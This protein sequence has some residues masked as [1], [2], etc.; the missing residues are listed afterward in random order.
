LWKTIRIWLD[1][2]VN[3]PMI[4][5]GCFFL[6]TTSEVASNSAPFYLKSG[7]DRNVTKA[8]EIMALTASTSTNKTNVDAYTSFIDLGLD[9]RTSFLEKVWILDNSL[10]ISDLD[11]ELKR[12]LYFVS[13]RDNMNS[14]TT[15]LEGWW[16]SRVIKQLHKEHDI[17]IIS[18]ELYNEI[19]RLREQFSAE[20]LPIDDDIMRSD[21][22]EGSYEDRVFIHQLRIIGISNPKRIIFAIKDY[23]RAF[24]QRSRW[25]NEQ[26]LPINELDRYEDKLIELWDRKFQ[27]M[28]DRIGER[29]AEDKMKEAATTLY[30]W[31][32]SED[33][34]PIRSKVEESS[35]ARGSFHILSD[36]LTI[37][38]HPEFQQR[39]Q[40][41]LNK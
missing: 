4:S 2:V 5:T 22:D 7:T 12:E 1:I 31:I 16:T 32:E 19:N 11:S 10:S 13:S 24:S 33:L 8:S 21:I 17:P 38:W 27:Q 15:R 6:V 14:F 20:N 41:I 3:K 34:P 39:L 35:I 40:S 36:K 23:Y 37:G 28:K 18:E 26:L 29:A 25:I 9:D 30:E